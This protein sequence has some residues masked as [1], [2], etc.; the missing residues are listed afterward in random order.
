M[1]AYSLSNMVTDASGFSFMASMNISGKNLVRRILTL[2][3]TSLSVI[4][5]PSKAAVCS[6]TVGLVELQNRFSRYIRAPKKSEHNAVMI[7][8]HTCCRKLEEA[9][10]SMIESYHSKLEEA[11]CDSLSL[12]LL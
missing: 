7:Y 6:R 8:I 12:L 1:Q 9:I 4:I 5:L 11:L 2:G 10:K 3:P